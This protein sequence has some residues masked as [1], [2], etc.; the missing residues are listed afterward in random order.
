MRLW[1]C[2]F[3]RGSDGSRTRIRMAGR[4]KRLMGLETKRLIRGVRSRFERET[5]ALCCL[6]GGVT[7]IRRSTQSRICR[8]RFCRECRRRDARDIMKKWYVGVAAIVLLGGCKSKSGANGDAAGPEK[9]KV[10]TLADVDKEM[11]EVGGQPS[12]KQES[13]SNFAKVHPPN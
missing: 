9:Q 7:W 6:A 12:K 13:V 2:A 8:T 3:I 1:R 11:K 10:Y 5:T 4:I